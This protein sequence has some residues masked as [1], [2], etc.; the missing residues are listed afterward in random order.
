MNESDMNEWSRL[1][2][3]LSDGESNMKETKEM[4]RKDLKYDKSNRDDRGEL[5]NLF[6]W[7]V[8]YRVYVG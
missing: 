8:M 6:I 5:R 7:F 2:G 3:W 1:V 4:M